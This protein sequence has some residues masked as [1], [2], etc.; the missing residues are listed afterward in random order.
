MKEN[1]AT[2]LHKSKERL[3]KQRKIED[4]RTELKIEIQDKKL[5]VAKDR[6]ERIL[7]H[8]EL[9]DNEFREAIRLAAEKRID[10]SYRDLIDAL[11]KTKK[12]IN[13]I[14]GVGN[15]GEARAIFLPIEIFKKY[16]QIDGEVIEALPANK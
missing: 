5:Q 14:D 11:D 1:L 9:L 7:S 12:H 13:I 10:A 3:Q 4:A 15:E 2:I 8:R 6:V 16:K